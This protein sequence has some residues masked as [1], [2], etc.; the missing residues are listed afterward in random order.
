M[1]CNTAAFAESAGE[2]YEALPREAQEWMLA[3]ESGNLM[4]AGSIVQKILSGLFRE[5]TDAGGFLVQ[6]IVISVL[7]GFLATL[8]SSIDFPEVSK[9]AYLAGYGALVIAAVRAVFPVLQSVSETVERLVTFM[10]TLLPVYIGF[11]FSGGNATA[12]AMMNPTLI[13]ATQSVSLL[14]SYG[15]VPLIFCMLAFTAISGLTED[16]RL[17]A[18]TELM[19]SFLK[20]SMVFVLT[21]FVGILSVQGFVS[22]AAD[23]VIANTARLAAEKFVPVVGG[24][25]SGAADTVLGSAL[26]VK[27]ACGV[28]G[29]VGLLAIAALPTLKLIAVALM[30]KLAAAV[31]APITDKRVVKCLNG[32]SEVLNLM[33]AVLGTVLFLFIISCAILL[34]T[35]NALM[36]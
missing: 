9:I 23:G 25:L 3:D 21:I 28:V 18:I 32:F 12:A 15:A 22:R 29:V 10:Q 34:G 6:L 7:T 4:D 26:V 8:K 2:L 24:I 14:V 11:L 36:T 30:L 33:F 20:T 16:D 1:L 35:M 27:N 31:V 5:I 19:R 17:G 13:F